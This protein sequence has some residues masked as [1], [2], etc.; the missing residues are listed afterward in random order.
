MIEVLLI[1][2]VFVF[3]IFLLFFLC[4]Q[5]TRIEKLEEEQ[6]MCQFQIDSLKLVVKGM[7]E[8]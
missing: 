2:T 1:A 6:R 8:E 7:K 3:L 4:E 5:H